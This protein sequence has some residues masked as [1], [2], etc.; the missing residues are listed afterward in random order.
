M[1]EPAQLLIFPAASVFLTVAPAL[2]F[3][4]FLPQFASPEDGPP[5]PQM[6]RL[7]LLFALQT[8]LVF[9]T[10]ALLRDRPPRYGYF[11]WPAGVCGIGGKTGVDGTLNVKR[12][13]VAR[14]YVPVHT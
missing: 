10:A 13:T 1:P 11:A 6:P 8:L 12:T 3:L 5:W 9:S 7:G 2:F 4:A 14:G